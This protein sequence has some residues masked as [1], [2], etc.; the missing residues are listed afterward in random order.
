MEN[1]LFN[2]VGFKVM[3]LLLLISL[4]FDG[5][6]YILPSNYRPLTVIFLAVMA[7]ILGVYILLKDRGYLKRIF[8]SPYYLII[9][10]Y[11]LSVLN[12]FYQVYNRRVPSSGSYDFIITLTLGM[13]T[14]FVFDYFFSHHAQ[15]SPSAQD[16]LNTV[17]RW[18]TLI[19]IPVLLFGVV[20][21]LVSFNLL[22]IE[23]KTFFVEH[24][25][26]KVFTRIQL[27]S[28]EP[29][30]ASMQLLFIMP[31]IMYQLKRF[32]K[33]MIPLL[34][35]TIVLFLM[36]FSLQGFL[37]LIAALGLLFLVYIRKVNLKLT[38]LVSLTVIVLSVASF[39]IVRAV[40]GDTYFITRFYKIF[41][42]NSIEAFFFI[43]GSVFIR[44]FYPLAALIMFVNHPWLGVGGGNYSFAFNDILY[45]TFPRATRFME[46]QQ[47]LINYEAN[48]KNIFTR[49]LGENGLLIAPFFILFV[50]RILNR[51]KNIKIDQKEILTF[52]IIII[53]ANMLQFDSYVYI[54]LWFML[55]LIVNLVFA[56]RLKKQP[57]DLS[58]SISVAMTTFNG[59]KHLAEQL[60]SILV[61]LREKDEIIVSDDGSTD[62]TLDLL[63]QYAQKDSRIKI[64]IHE[65]LG[66]ARNFERAVS[67]CSNPVIFLSDQDDVWYPHKV[68]STL[69]L[70]A[71]REVDLIMHNAD[72]IDEQGVDSGNIL[73]KRYKHGVFNNLLISSYWGHCMAFRRSMIENEPDMPPK[74]KHHDMWIGL[75]AE[76][77]NASL[78]VKQSWVKHRIHSSNVSRK[79]S[80][81]ERILS[82]LHMTF[83]YV[84][85]MKNK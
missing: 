38:L 79:L 34:I 45:E 19:Y 13:I 32:K 82:R 10:F 73:V 1:R 5:F 55:A 58:T 80:I 78:F 56:Y 61:Q 44:L 8:K 57:I 30:W 27:F 54:K 9:L 21:V 50:S 37:T 24:T 26:K 71:D 85:H 23:I 18:L 77:N 39:F 12:S 74:L 60:D 70:F 69:N 52:W 63:N 7:P 81:K 11:I 46:V 16:F 72:I 31:I 17:F 42:V 36:S 51:F 40:V 53:F 62:Q 83:N 28:A 22:P 59:E 47:N 66:H 3:Y 68:E 64:D 15:A 29:S 49:L 48:S 14:F 2:H 25:A 84:F 20:E 43:D 35:I 4:P 75:I 41:E 65:N 6:A 76:R 33:I 67:L